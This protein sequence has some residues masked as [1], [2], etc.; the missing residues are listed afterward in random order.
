M[1][2]LLEGDVV[3]S[4][5]S[6]RVFALNFHADYRC[7]NSGACCTANWDVPVELPFYTSLRE[8]VTSGRLQPADTAGVSSPFIID[9]NLPEGAAAILERD[10]DGRCVFY[11]ATA[12][13]CIVHRDLGE[14][15]LPETCRHFPRVSVQD[16]RGT[17]VS[18]SHFCP[19][20]ASMLFRDLP[21]EI[22]SAPIAFP[23][24]DYDGLLVT[25]DDLPP[26]LTPRVLMDLDGY[27]AWERHMVARFRDVDRRP[28]SIM[29]TLNRDAQVLGRWRPGAIA[30]DEAVAQLSAEYVDGA[31]SGLRDCLQRFREVIA[32]VPE[33]VRP[34]P[35]EDQLEA[36]FANEVEPAWEAFH[37]PVNRYLAAKAFAS[38][39]A[40]QG[41]G[42]RTI[43]RGL[44]AALALV[45]VESARQCRNAQRTLDRE[46]LLE[47][48]RQAD[49]L[50]NHLAIGE[51]L[52]RA[53]SVVES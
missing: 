52:A 13:R 32:A 18:L 49:F 29:A 9:S 38:W 36:P 2:Q 46:L 48:I 30:L 35:D 10:E 39:T 1:V 8:A 31:E 14:A 21:V 28:A 7:Q 50:L 33:D 12:K 16:R 40:Y 6:A 34:E 26:L 41:R 25:D 24:A 37:G 47:A 51:D 22:V 53:W 23:H 44:D 11:A 4:A 20:A 45:R 43:V 17:F 42:V 3:G 19:T 15:A 5:R 27:T